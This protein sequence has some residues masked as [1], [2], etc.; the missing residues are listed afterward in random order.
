ME[1]LGFLFPGQGSQYVGM[2]KDLYDEFPEAKQTYQKAKDVLGFDIRSLSFGGPELELR[3]SKNAQVAILVH[4]IAAL[5]LLEKEGIRPSV[6]A[7]HSLGEYSAL[8]AAGSL[9]FENALQLVRFRGEL[10]SEAGEKS[11][12]TMAAIIGLSGED[13]NLVC[14]EAS[15]VGT[16]H[17]ANYN[18]PGQTVISGEIEAVERA[19]KIAKAKGAKRAVVLNVSGAFHSP[20]METAF[21]K[22]EKV[23]SKTEIREPKIPVV[24]N[25]TGEAVE[26]AEG[27]RKALMSQIVSPV[28]W[29]ES[30]KKMVGLGVTAFVEVGPGNVLRGLLRRIAPEARTL[31]AE[32]GESLTQ[33]LHTLRAG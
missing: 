15:E 24:V 32:D 22:F 27:L 26:R 1:K 25:V 28:R 33:A 19:V 3:E 17:V 8:V 4:S 2:G 10:M 5:T 14:Q 11:P 9:I 21:D 31:N 23:L 6:V 7:G 12:G 18:S 16:V 29:M 20:L 30:M 13:V